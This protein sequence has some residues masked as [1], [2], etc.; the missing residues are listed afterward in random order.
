MHLERENAP[1]LEAVHDDS[2]LLERM[3]AGFAVTHSIYAAAK[4]GIADLLEGGPRTAE[5]LAGLVGV[6]GPSLYRLLRALASVGVFTETAP[7]R[8]ALTPTAQRLR[9]DAPDSLRA[10][11]IVTGEIV[12]RSWDGLMHSLQTGQP[13]FESVFGMPVFEYLESHPETAA[14]FDGHQEQGGRALHAAVARSLDFDANDTIIDLGGGN[15]SLAA[16]ILERH[17]K[18]RA[19]IFDLPHVIERA[20]AARDPALDGRYEFIAGSIFEHV[21][22]GADAYL[23]SRV[24]HDWDDD[25]AA[26]ILVNCRRAMR[27]D[28]RLLVIERLV[29]PGD[30]SHESKFMDLNMLVIAGGRER[31]EDEFRALLERCCLQLDRVINTGTAVSV[32]EATPATQQQPE[33][34]RNV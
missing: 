31:N 4:L 28:A 25:Q 27:T 6:H 10:W 7:A 23:L 32:L 15:G 17:P 34:G 30:Q 9:T 5:E 22:P 12:A 14:A 29:P 8:F 26:A 21:P 18:L 2:G 3:L 19:A 16:A 33:S 1:A 13:A 24:L 20:Q 11:A